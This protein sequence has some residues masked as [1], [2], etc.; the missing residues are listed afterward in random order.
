M[1]S[2]GIASIPLIVTFLLRKKCKVCII[3]LTL[4]L[5]MSCIVWIIIADFSLVIYQAVPY[6]SS[7]LWLL[8]E[9]HPK[10]KHLMAILTPTMQTKSEPLRRQAE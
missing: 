10:N 8:A 4:M 2:F 1:F 9:N 3:T 5:M 6:I 7:F